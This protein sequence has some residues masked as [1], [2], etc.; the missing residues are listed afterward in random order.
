MQSSIRG[1]NILMINSVV[2]LQGMIILHVLME[3]RFVVHI[4]IDLTIMFR[5]A[6]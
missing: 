1:I 2:F 4:V 5:D 3:E 6:G